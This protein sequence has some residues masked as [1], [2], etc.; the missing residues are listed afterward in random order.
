MQSPYRL[1]SALVALSFSSVT[2][3][4]ALALK[5]VPPLI[6]AASY[7]D[8]I[9]LSRYWVS[10]KYD[11][12]RAWWDG[13][14]FVTRGGGVYHAPAW[15]TADLP[16]QILDGELWIG[17]NQFQP[18]M[19]IIRDQVPDD[20]AWRK[21]KFMVFDAPK[22]EGH[23]NDRQLQIA[24]L[25]SMVSVPWVEHVSQFRVR[26]H[27]ELLLRLKAITKQGGEGLMLQREDMSYLSGRHYGLVKLKLHSDAEARVLAH[28]PGKGKYK[29]MMGSVLVQDDAGMQFKIGSGFTDS[30]RQN[31][32]PVGSLITYR[33]QGRT[34]SGKPRFARYLRL[35][36]E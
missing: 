11:G 34:Q 6:L 30:E 36:A 7:H 33:Y 27:D 16:D 12:A 15:F 21:V 25:L 1:L 19:K 3:T 5:Q 17:R 14:K 2:S 23:F 29:H 22:A 4:P 18:L 32:P 13:E 35:H 26:S 10:E 9:D 24:R 20:I 8:H 31:P 28:F